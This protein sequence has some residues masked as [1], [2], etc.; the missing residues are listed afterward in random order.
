MAGIGF[1]LR[2]LLRHDDYFG[3]IRAY[4]YAGIIGAGP[5]VISIL[6]VVLLGI[7]STNHVFP[8]NL[9]SQFETSVTYL[10]AGSLIFSGIWQLAFTRYVSDRLFAREHDLVLPN[11][12]GLLVAA[13]G[14][15]FVLSGTATLFLFEGT[16]ALY[17]LLMS[18][19]FCLLTGV[20][21][22]TVMLTGLKHYRAIISAFVVGY[23]VALSVGLLL[24]P[25]GLVGLLFA[26]F[27]GQFLLFVGLLAVIY[28]SYPSRQFLAFDFLKR[29]QM[30]ASLLA[31][32]FFYNAGI[33]ADKIVFWFTPQTSQAVIGPLRAS[34][35][36]DLPIFLAYLSIIPGMAVFL[37]RVE[38]DFVDYYDQFYDAVREGGSLSHIRNMRNGMVTSAKT[39][40]FDIIKIQSLATIVAFVIGPAVLR[41]LG[42]SLLYIPLFKIDVVGAGLQVVLMGILNIFFYLDR[43]ARVVWLTVIFFG[44][45][46]VLSIIST[47]LGLYFYGFGFSISLLVSVLIGLVWLDK[48]MERVE[49]QTFM[50]QPW[51]H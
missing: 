16:G 19:L 36:Y 10:I 43:R 25:F 9:V 35:I 15:G 2:K 17:R 20:W 40:I 50:L 45:N 24:R 5:W 37:M 33:W 38:T 46:L 29:G 21:V 27:L 30:Y 31:C 8:P 44:L 49:Y 6:G 41:F 42:I 3:L 18:A 11:L 47:H 26:F 7:L 23:G 4:S 32:G 51:S 48:D 39:G 13:M 1:E 34:A 28:R 12:N 22:I 14:S